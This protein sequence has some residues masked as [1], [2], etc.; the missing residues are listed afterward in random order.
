MSF[1]QLIILYIGFLPLPIWCIVFCVNLVEILKKVKN[2]EK[3]TVNT[4][5]LSLSF[6]IIMCSMA[7][8]IIS[9]H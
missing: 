5:W 4:F 3:T 2:E 6:T 9:S 1:I 8:L 7:S